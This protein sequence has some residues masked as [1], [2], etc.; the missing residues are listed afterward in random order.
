MRSGADLVV[1]PANLAPLALSNNLV[2][3]HDAAALRGPG[4][5]SAGYARW[6]ARVL[7]LIARR[8]KAIVAPSEFSRDE[9]A[10]LTGVPLERITVIAGGVDSRFSPRA[11]S[12]QA[13]SR[14]GL[15]RPYVLTVA[16]RVGRK[17]LSVLDFAARSLAADGVDVVVAGGD[18]PQFRSDA[19]GEGAV[20]HIGYVDDALLPGLYAGASA[21]V[22]PSLHE[23]FGLTAVE[24]MASGVPTVLSQ[25]GALP[26]TAMEGAIYFD[27]LDRSQMLSQ[28]RSAIGNRPLAKAGIERASGFTWERCADAVDQLVGELL[29]SK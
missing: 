21:F 5:Y 6:Q 9:I 19:L 3:M 18:R 15:E 8:A 13:M 12:A 25:A 7:P 29:A 28:L 14:L 26:Q 10:E 11:D 23:G 24:A 27:P 2:V 1:S 17:N 4:W 16:S 20:R 22:L